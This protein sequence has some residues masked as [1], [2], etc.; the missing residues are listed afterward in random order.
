M[1]EL[2]AEPPF[3]ALF[4]NQNVSFSYPAGPL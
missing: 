4:R 2:P 1:P 3:F